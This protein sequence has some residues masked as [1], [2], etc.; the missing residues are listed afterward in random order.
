MS[1]KPDAE[2]PRVNKRHIHV[3][4]RNGVLW[5]ALDFDMPVMAQLPGIHYSSHRM[6]V[7]PLL[8]AQIDKGEAAVIQT[9]L[10]E[11][12][13]AVIL[14]DLKPVASPKPSAPK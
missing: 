11:A 1:V 13:D 2:P 8:S 3:G 12:H 5:P 6:A 4:D 7:H 14:D 9:A 10:D